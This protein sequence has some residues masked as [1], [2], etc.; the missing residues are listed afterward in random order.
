MFD[1]ASKY[2]EEML[3]REFSP[4]FS[5]I[6]VL[7][8]GFCNVGRIEEACGVLSKSL[9]HGEAPHLDSWAIIIPR[10]CE[11]EENAKIRDVLEDVLKIEIKGD[12]RLVEAGGIGLENYLIRKIRAK[13]R[14]S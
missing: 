7:V 2:V 6:D 11:V 3:S 9:K 14:L 12:T 10:I 8:K 1:E 13:S 4:H 5:V